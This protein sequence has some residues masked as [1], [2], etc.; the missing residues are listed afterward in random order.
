[1]A[2]DFSSLEEVNVRQ[3]TDGP[4]GSDWV[5]LRQSGPSVPDD[6]GDVITPEPDEAPFRAF[7]DEGGAK[8]TV[9][10]PKGQG[11][12][13]DG[14]VTLFTCQTQ[15]WNGL[16][17]DVDFIAA[18]DKQGRRADTV[19]RETTGELWELQTATLWEAGRFWALQARLVNRG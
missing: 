1:M 10:Q 17:E 18:D 12:Q 16:T 9:K 7:V 15:T 6:A 19:R 8:Q 13:R 5:R 11:D 14:T 2:V 3:F 4:A